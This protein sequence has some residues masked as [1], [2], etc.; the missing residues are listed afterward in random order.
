MTY[1]M[2]FFFKRS[3]FDKKQSDIPESIHLTK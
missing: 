3:I 1:L 2:G